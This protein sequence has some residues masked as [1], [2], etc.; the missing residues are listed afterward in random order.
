MRFALQSA[1]RSVFAAVVICSFADM[2]GLP[3]S[4]LLVG[5]VNSLAVILP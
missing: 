4:V 5:P 3:S 1:C 2:D